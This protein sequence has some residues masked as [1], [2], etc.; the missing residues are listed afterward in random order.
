ME[1][2]EVT[3]SK[4]KISDFHRHLRFDSRRKVP[5]GRAL[6]LAL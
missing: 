3:N 4:Y 1:L 5:A 6:V 2:A